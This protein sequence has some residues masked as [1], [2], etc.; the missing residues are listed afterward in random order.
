[1]DRT[2][3]PLPWTTVALIAVLTTTAGML[4]SVVLLAV[5]DGLT[6]VGGPPTASSG[7]MLPSFVAAIAV[8][9]LHLIVLPLLLL[10][11]NARLLGPR[12][13]R[14]ASWPSP[15]PRRSRSSCWR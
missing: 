9:P 2:A 6:D 12:S 1:M 14:P 7:G 3:G 4:L 10:M 11:V 15:P 13:L 5:Y 8:A